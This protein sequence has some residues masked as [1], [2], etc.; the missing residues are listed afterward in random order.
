MRKT[1]VILRRKAQFWPCFVAVLFRAAP[2]LR[3]FSC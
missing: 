2:R 1:V 3:G